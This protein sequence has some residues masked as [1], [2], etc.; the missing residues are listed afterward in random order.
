MDNAS[1]NQMHTLVHQG[2]YGS[3]REAA[4]DFVQYAQR[5]SAA[6][7]VFETAYSTLYGCQSK[8]IDR[9]A[10][11]LGDWFTEFMNGP[12]VRSEFEAFVRF[13][14]FPQN[15]FQLTPNSADRMLGL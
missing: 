7:K 5:R 15:S 4:L 8:D 2:H 14:A 1:I 3:V 11:R 6:L 10:G 12:E 13:R 9:P